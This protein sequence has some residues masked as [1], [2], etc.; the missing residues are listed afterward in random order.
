MAKTL[1]PCPFCGS[2]DLLP[3]FHTGK[4]ELLVCVSCDNCDV[5]G[6]TVI[7]DENDNDRRKAL[8]KAHE[9]WNKRK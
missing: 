5:E 1:K 6:P 4:R 3:S 7:I 9:A 8:A 2:D